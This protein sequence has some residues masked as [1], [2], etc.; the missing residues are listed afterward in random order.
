MARTAR[1]RPYQRTTKAGTKIWTVPYR[2]AMGRSREKSFRDDFQAAQRFADQLNAA[3]RPPEDSMTLDELMKQWEEHYVDT[4]MTARA[5]ENYAT[6]YD[7]YIAPELADL[8]VQE[9]EHTRSHL[10]RWRSALLRDGISKSRYDRSRTVLSSILRYGEE[11][12]A[13]STNPARVLRPYPQHKHL[14]E[15]GDAPIEAMSAL[16]IERL[17]QELLLPIRGNAQPTQDALIV[18][19]VAW[20]GLRPGELCRLDAEDIN[21]DRVHVYGAT[22]TT[23]RRRPPVLDVVR[24]EIHAHATK[25]PLLLTRQ[26]EESAPHRWSDTDWHNWQSRRFKPALNAVVERFDLDEK[27]LK[28][29]AYDLR[30]SWVSARL[31]TLPDTQ[32]S[33]P[34]R[35]AAEAGHSLRVQQDVYAHMEP[36]RDGVRRSMADQLAIARKQATEEYKAVREE[37][38]RADAAK[39]EA[40]KARRAELARKRR[41]ERLERDK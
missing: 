5:A 26:R 14:A 29:R 33:D 40:R 16:L 27:L 39:E 25:G 2:N 22:K 12:G 35:I 7:L 9:L 3:M 13:I 28:H 1:A 24:D 36:T 10:V 17:R 6:H 30:H 4:D 20:I 32:E 21:D 31:S 37:L 15:G 41:Q 19:A 8:S 18:S 38:A 23:I 34:L 11:I